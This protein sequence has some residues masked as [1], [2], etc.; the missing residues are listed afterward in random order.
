MTD[1]QH[2]IKNTEH[3]CICGQRLTFEPACG[4]IVACHCTRCEAR[5]LDYGEV[6]YFRGHGLSLTA[7]Y[8]DWLENWKS[9]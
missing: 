4:D 3:R 1:L 2:A 5:S 6:V 9:F 7:A 8:Q